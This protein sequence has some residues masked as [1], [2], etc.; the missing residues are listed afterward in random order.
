M[1]SVFISF[2]HE[3]ER[4]AK[5]VQRFLRNGL[6][7]W[8]RTQS[9]Q[10]YEVFLSSDGSQVFAGE[11][12][13]DRIDQELTKAS[14]VVL[15]MSKRSVVRPWLNFEAGAAWFGKGHK[16]I[17]PVC[18]GELIKNSLPYPFSSL[19]AAE[20]PKGQDYL[21]TSVQE[22]LEK[23]PSPD[24]FPPASTEKKRGRLMTLLTEGTAAF[25]TIETALAEFKDEADDVYSA[26]LLRGAGLAA[27]IAGALASFAATLWIERNNPLFHKVILVLWVLLPFGVLLAMDWRRRHRLPRT[28]AALYKVMLVVA[29]ACVAAYEVAAVWPRASPDWVFLVVPLCSLILMVILKTISAFSSWLGWWH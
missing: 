25:E 22:Y 10:K 24:L 18:Y 13:L 17:I 5:A 1:G 9:G 4:V 12:W 26:G 29:V 14:I 7:R 20:L 11:N 23:L 19:N 27:T 8:A 3:D 15:M 2:V 16:L 28:T 6:Q 21:L